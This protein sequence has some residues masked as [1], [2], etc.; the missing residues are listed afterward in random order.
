MIASASSTA[1]G[2][3][4]KAPAAN[5]KRRSRREKSPLAGTKPGP[6]ESRMEAQ[7]AVLRERV[8]SRQ[9]KPRK[10]R[11]WEPDA[12]DHQVFQWV[13]F[14]GKTQQWAAYQL[15]ISQPT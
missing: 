6:G 11:T 5:G 2:S 12:K 14:E 4:D 15:G 9:G 7:P 1:N 13:K 3:A 8:C 10:R